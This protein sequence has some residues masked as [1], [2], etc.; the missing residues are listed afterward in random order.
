MNLPL[1]KKEFLIKLLIIVI[2]LKFGVAVDVFSNELKEIIAD[3]KTLKACNTEIEELCKFKP[4]EVIKEQE[5][6]R[7]KVTSLTEQCRTI[8]GKELDRNR[9]VTLPESLRR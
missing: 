8:V 1:T 7:S 6:L 3:R 5:C 2:T 4:T 9:P